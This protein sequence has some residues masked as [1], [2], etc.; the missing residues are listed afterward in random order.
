MATKLLKKCRI[1]AKYFTIV[2][3]WLNREFACEKMYKQESPSTAAVTVVQNNYYFYHCGAGDVMEPSQLE[4][5]KSK[6]E[7]NEQ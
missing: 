4:S 3:I 5:M 1:Y 7:Q 2:G 6:T